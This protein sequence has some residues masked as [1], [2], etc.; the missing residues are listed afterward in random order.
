[1]RIFDCLQ[2]RSILLIFSLC[3]GVGKTAIIEAMA[4]HAEKILLME[5][6]RVHHPRVLKCAPTGKAAGLI[7]M[8]IVIYLLNFQVL[9]HVNF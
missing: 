9:T 6:K 4:I 7:G 5:G 2:Y 8:F 1:M 3:L